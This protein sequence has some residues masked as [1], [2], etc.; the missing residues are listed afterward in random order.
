[1]RIL[2]FFFIFSTFI[3]SAQY[4]FEKFN[5]PKTEKYVFKQEFN[6]HF[7]MEIPSFY[8]N[9]DNLE[10][11][12]S[13][14]NDEDSTT[15]KILRNNNIIKSC[16][17]SLLIHLLDT[18]YVADI[19]GDGLKDIKLIIST[20]SCGIA[21]LNKNV[22]YLFQKQNND[23]ILISFNDMI[24][25]GRSERDFNKDGNYEII[26]MN[27]ESYKNHNYWTFNVF[28]FKNDTLVNVNSK[29]NYPIMIQFLNR[30][31]YSITKNLS[32]QQMKKFERKLPDN[33]KKN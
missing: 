21:S 19:N 28:N 4:P 30:E 13:Y 8:S 14:K 29:Y 2:V 31:N 3:A 22:I 27:L 6:G 18:M 16:D 10:L 32:S 7:E 1:M 12:F 33:F 25:E 11:R 17:G 23:F 26:T 15:I 9:G 20:G 24:N 5:T